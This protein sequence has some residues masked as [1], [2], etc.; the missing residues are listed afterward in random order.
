MP[1]ETT[2]IALRTYALDDRDWVRDANVEHYTQ[3]EGFDAT[4]AKAVSDALDFLE[5]QIENANSDFIIAHANRVPVGCIFFAPETATT[6]RIRLFYLD[7]AH[8]GQGNGKRMLARVI[9]RAIAGGFHRISVSTFE[10]HRKACALYTSFGFQPTVLEPAM[11]FGKEMRQIDFKLD[12]D[13]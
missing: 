7:P 1:A 6:G 3:A 8:R 11:S 10:R 9:E 12:L 2:D 13:G 5:P 4:F